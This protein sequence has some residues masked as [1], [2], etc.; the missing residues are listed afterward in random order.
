[1]II[2]LNLLP[3]SPFREEATLLRSSKISMLGALARAF[4]NIFI[5]ITSLSPSTIIILAIS[6]GSDEEFV[7]RLTFLEDLGTVNDKHLQSGSLR[8]LCR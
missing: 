4:S 8:Y 3:I 6:F 2:S 5:S 7:R 1:M